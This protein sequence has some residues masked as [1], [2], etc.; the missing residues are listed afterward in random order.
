MPF[1]RKEE[2]PEAYDEIKVNISI[3]A[4]ELA[5]WFDATFVRGKMKFEMS[6]GTLKTTVDESNEES[7]RLKED[8]DVFAGKRKTCGNNQR[9]CKLPCNYGLSQRNC[10]QPTYGIGDNGVTMIDRFGANLAR[11]RE[12][13][14]AS[15][16]QTN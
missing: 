15:A 8:R 4:V 16:D 6:S 11:G 14:G 13:G 10:L 3:E 5:E 7:R 2:I 12:S 1:L 9:S